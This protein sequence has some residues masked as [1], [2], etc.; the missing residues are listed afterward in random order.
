MS[1]TTKSLIPGEE[2]IYTSTF[3]RKI[4]VLNY[5]LVLL[6]CLGLVNSAGITSS[7]VFLGLCSIFFIKSVINLL[8]TEYSITNKKVLTKTGLIS[9]S[10]DELPTTKVEGIDV[11]QGIIGRI[12]GFGNVIVTGTG[13]Q[14][15]VF[16][17]ID[18]PIQF[19][20]TLQGVL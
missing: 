12:F 11:K 14:Q 10:T 18:N 4:I 1:Y 19:K 6:F 3:S 9:R 15:V 16:M 5:S 20:K 2:I 8:S 13:V 17:D 7:L